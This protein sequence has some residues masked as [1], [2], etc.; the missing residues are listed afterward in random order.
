MPAGGGR[1]PQQTA[2]SLRQSINFNGSYSHSASDSKTVFALKAP[3]LTR[4]HVHPFQR[5]ILIKQALN[6]AKGRI[7]LEVATEDLLA[8]QQEFSAT[9]LTWQ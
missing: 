8:E 5:A 3:G 6:L 7:V 2:K 4:L 9:Q 1:R